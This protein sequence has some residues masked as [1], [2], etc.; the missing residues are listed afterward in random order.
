MSRTNLVFDSVAYNRELRQARQ[1][2]AHRGSQPLPLGCPVGS[3]PSDSRSR[4]PSPGP[5]VWAEPTAPFHFAPQ[6]L[7][8]SDRQASNP[9]TSSSPTTDPAATS[10]PPSPA[11]SSPSQPGS[12]LPQPSP[13]S[14]SPRLPTFL[15]A[16]LSLLDVLIPL[17]PQVPG[18]QILRL[19]DQVGRVFFNDN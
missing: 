4:A 2:L 6:A 3:R 18:S 12:A 13:P 11:A 14:G 16:M 1:A 19:V 15:P 10:S 9:M 8:L 7:G 17:S 5:G